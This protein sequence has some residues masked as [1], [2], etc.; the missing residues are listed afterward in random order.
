MFLISSVFYWI[1]RALGMWLET[2]FLSLGVMDLEFWGLVNWPLEDLPFFILWRNYTLL[3][4]FLPK[5]PKWDLI[6][7]FSV[8]F[9]CYLTLCSFW[10][11]FWIWIVDWLYWFKASSFL[12]YW[13]L[14]L[15]F[16]PVLSST[17]A[18]WKLKG[19]LSALRYSELFIYMSELYSDFFSSSIS[20]FS[21]EK[22][23]GDCFSVWVSLG[24]A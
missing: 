4:V 13:N 8:G 2:K 20:P 3:S 12:Y 21:L 22:V 24:L 18:L 11:W 9:R 15:C 17:F 7:G 23:D 1:L 5:L 6:I 10:F 14:L 16:R 19:T